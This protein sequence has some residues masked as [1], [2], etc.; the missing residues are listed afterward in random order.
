MFPRFKFLV[1]LQNHPAIEITATSNDCPCAAMTAVLTA[2]YR[3]G[4]QAPLENINYLGMET[5]K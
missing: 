3:L 1:K 5:R 4:T 2:Q